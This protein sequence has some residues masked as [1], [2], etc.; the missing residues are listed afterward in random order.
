MI[1]PQFMAFLMPQIK[2]TLINH[3]DEK[4]ATIKN[5][6]RREYKTNTDLQLFN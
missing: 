4:I 6:G 3:F 5:L 1:Q 2:S